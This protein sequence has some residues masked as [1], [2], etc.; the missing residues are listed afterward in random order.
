MLIYNPSAQ[1]AQALVWEEIRKKKTRKRTDIRFWARS[2]DEYHLCSAAINNYESESESRSVVS[3]SLR[4]MEC[5]VHGILQ[6]RILEWAAFAFCRGSSQ[7]RSR[8]QVSCI[9]GGFFLPAEPRNPPSNCFQ[10]FHNRY[11][12]C[13]SC[14]KASTNSEL[15]PW[16]YFPNCNTGKWNASKE[17]Q[18]CWTDE[19]ESR[20]G[21][22]L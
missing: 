21:W 18:P 9:A 4:P 2:G 14:K 15:S 3:D 5:I 8:T 16:S 1:V 10:E 11:S 6:A 13:G 7:P 20:L 12:G 22:V 19:P 17:Q